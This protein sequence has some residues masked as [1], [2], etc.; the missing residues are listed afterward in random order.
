MMIVYNLFPLLAGPFPG[1]VPH[2]ERAAAMGFD[3]LFVN[4]VQ[5]P[6]ASGREK[7]FSGAGEER[8]FEEARETLAQAYSDFA[9]SSPLGERV[10]KVLQEHDPNLPTPPADAPPKPFVP[11][12]QLKIVDRR[13]SGKD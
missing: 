7:D 12:D 13:T 9:A 10:F 1:W 3:W 8:I 11:L 2:I 4:P 5:R 6:G